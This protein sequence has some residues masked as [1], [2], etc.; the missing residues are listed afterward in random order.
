MLLPA[1]Y[2]PATFSLTAMAV[3]GT[4]D[5]FGGDGAR[6]TNAFLFTT[7]VHLSGVALMV[8]IASALHQSFP[9]RTSVMWALLAGAVG[10]LSLA[11]FYRALATGN[12]GLT[13]PVSAVLSAAIPTL[14]AAFSEGFPGYRHLAGFVLAVIGVWLIS[15]TEDAAGH[16]QGIGWAVVAGIGFAGFYLC[17]HQAGAGSPL[18]LAAW[19]RL[20]SLVITVIVVLAARQFQAI[21]A[22]VLGIAI[23]T[24]FLDVTGSALFV[25]A[26]QS[27]RLDTA[28]VL[29]SLYP[30]ITVLLARIFLHEHF[31]RGRTIGMLA[32][33]AAVPMIAG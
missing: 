23:F 13:A 9:S 16:P 20:A 15:R 18:W 27:G 25:R 31:S 12:M 19:S 28:V 2:L 7:I 10:G 3:W 33:L 17:I 29:S 32:A 5:F 11:V 6:R 26:S 21:P 1:A 4:S 22:P 30:A 24:G 8:S 14:F